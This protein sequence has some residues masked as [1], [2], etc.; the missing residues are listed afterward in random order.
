[1]DLYKWTGKL[2]PLVD[3]DLLL[4]TFELARDIRELDMR[5]SAYDLSEWGYE[6]V[7][8]ETPAGRA[9][10]V[11]RQRDFAERAAPL[12]QR[13]LELNDKMAAHGYPGPEV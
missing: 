8:V 6:P 12:R 1:M 7:P 11:R 4:D 9:D 5:A 2:V 10:Y 13:L 3:S